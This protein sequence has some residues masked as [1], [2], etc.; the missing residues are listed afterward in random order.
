MASPTTYLDFDRAE[1]AS[2]RGRTP[3]TLTEEGPDRTK[4]VLH[5]DFERGPMRWLRTRI[6]DLALHMRNRESLR[7]LEDLAI[8]RT[9]P[10]D[11]P[12][13]RSLASAR[14]SQP[15]SEL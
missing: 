3:L 7:R 15:P 11:G 4:V 10:S 6:N 13:L 9:E 8:R 2:L 1:W 12:N 14:W 5:E